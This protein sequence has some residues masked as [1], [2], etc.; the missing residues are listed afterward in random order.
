MVRR[1]A[2]TQVSFYW[3]SADIFTTKLHG[4][5]KV[6]ENNRNFFNAPAGQNVGRTLRPPQMRAPPANA[7]GLKKDKEDF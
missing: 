4:V 5:L 7:L 1:W 6:E 3:I 2:D